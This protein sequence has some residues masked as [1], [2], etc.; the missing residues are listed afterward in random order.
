MKYCL[1]IAQIE[2]NS[3]ECVKKEFC[4]FIIPNLVFVYFVELGIDYS[5]IFHSLPLNYGDT[6]PCIIVL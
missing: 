1:K 4:F 3:A 5:S 6:K 2:E